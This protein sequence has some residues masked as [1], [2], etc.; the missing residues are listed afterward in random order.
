MDSAEE[1]FQTLI[2]PIEKQMIR[3]V[4]RIVHD[5][6]DAADVFQECL[7]EI[8]KKLPKVH[9]HPTPQAY[10]LRICIG[11]SYDALR[12]RALRRSREVQADDITL[13]AAAD[14]VRPHA[15]TDT[16]P[17]AD[18]G[19]ES[20]IHRAIAT[21]PPS[22]AHAVLLRAVEDMPYDA[23]GATLGCSEATARSHFSKGRARL[24]E[25]LTRLGIL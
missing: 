5:P 4:A 25:I 16:T 22:Q 17:A 3:T 11:R 1:I 15:S 12:R 2:A 24:H 14:R 19:K 13:E 8:W 10:I 18:S 7:A 23:I 9:C 20:T 6:D 21:L